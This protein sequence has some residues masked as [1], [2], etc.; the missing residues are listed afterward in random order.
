MKK[1]EIQ[2]I[3]EPAVPSSDGKTDESFE[4]KKKCSDEPAVKKQRLSNKEYKKNRSGQN[5]ALSD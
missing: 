1:V 3:I 4:E 2:Y 5:K